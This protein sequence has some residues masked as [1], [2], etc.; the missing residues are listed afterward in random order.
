MLRY[1]PMAE[2]LRLTARDMAV[3]FAPS[4]SLLIVVL[5]VGAWLLGVPLQ[6]AAADIERASVSQL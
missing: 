3:D 1:F 4:I 6:D 5:A 2:N